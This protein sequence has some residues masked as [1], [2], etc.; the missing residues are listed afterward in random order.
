MLMKIE[1]NPMVDDPAKTKLFELLKQRKEKED[2]KN[3]LRAKREHRFKE[4]TDGGMVES[5]AKKQVI[6]EIK[7][8]ES[9][10]NEAIVSKADTSRADL[11]TQIDAIC[12]DLAS[13]MDKA[14]ASAKDDVQRDENLSDIAKAK[15][16]AKLDEDYATDLARLKEQ[17]E[18]A[19]RVL[20]DGLKAA[21]DKDR[22]K[23]LAR[24][25]KTHLIQPQRS[26]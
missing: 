13:N 14:L 4:L 5:Q 22:K 24:L 10:K 16:I 26:R 11:T 20:E 19:K 18:R 17:Q 25:A 8:E 12:D 23:L 21:H 7:Q 3:R 1:K 6:Q 15:A 9:R 2:L